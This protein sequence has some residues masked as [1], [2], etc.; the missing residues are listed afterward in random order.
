MALLEVGSAFISVMP[1]TRLS[2]TEIIISHGTESINVNLQAGRV[3]VDVNPPVGTKTSMSVVSPVAVA[4]VR[5]TSFEFDTRNLTV[6]HGTVNFKGNRGYTSQVRA[7]F[8]AEVGGR[9][10]VSPPQP[11]TQLLSSSPAAEYITPGTTGGS[12][13]ITGGGSGNVGIKYP[14]N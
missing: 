5:G 8:T 6:N 14:S 4:A 2:L 10:S 7:G 1:V 9:G 13:G 3:R 11:D 12:G